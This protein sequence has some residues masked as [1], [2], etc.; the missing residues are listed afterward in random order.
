M[1]KHKNGGAELSEDAIKSDSLQVVADEEV[2]DNHVFAMLPKA[3]KPCGSPRVFHFAKIFE[4]QGGL[5]NWG[6]QYLNNDNYKIS[7]F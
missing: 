1:V 2:K 3:F 4:I 5:L 7:D 6:V